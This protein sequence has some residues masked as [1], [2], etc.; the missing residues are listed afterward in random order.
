M[1][2]GPLAFL[3]MVILISLSG[4]LVPGPNMA[5]VI[6]RGVGD[7]FAGARVSVGHAVAEIPLIIALFLG[8][9]ALGD[10]DV[11]TAIAVLG[12]SILILT[13]YQ[14]LRN[15]HRALQV[16]ASGG[17]STVM[18][19]FLTSIS[20]PYWWLWWATVG[21]VLVASGTAFGLW[22]LPAFIIV[23]I[24]VDLVCYQVI[25]MTMSA[26]AERVD[27][28]WLKWA[29]LVSGGIMVSFGVYFLL[30]GLSSLI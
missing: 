22:M 15:R 3:A 20:N 10:P 6:G 23:H 19:G 30:S 11:I 4:V 7:R 5:V 29:A 25:S 9:E 24:G 21:A 16:A 13:G 17:G 27:S 28:G 18:L 2:D 14:A 26:T 1:L 12:G 8:L